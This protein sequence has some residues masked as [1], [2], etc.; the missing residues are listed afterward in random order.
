MQ[1]QIKIVKSSYEQSPGGEECPS[2]LDIQEKTTRIQREARRAESDVTVLSESRF[3]PKN[4]RCSKN[5]THYV[6]EKLFI[7]KLFIPL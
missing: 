3:R 1:A 4:S 5:S 6:V 7:Q 2:S